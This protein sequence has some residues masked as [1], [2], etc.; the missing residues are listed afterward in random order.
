MNNEA[1]ILQDL[2]SNWI[3][4]VL[5]Y[6]QGAP[7]LR[8]V[9]LYAS[10]EQGTRYVNVCFDQGGTVVRPRSIQGIDTDLSRVSQMMSLF[11]DDLAAAEKSLSNVNSPAPTEYRVYY[12]PS[13]RKLDVQ[14]S[15]ELIYTNHSTKVPSEGIQDWLGDRAPKLL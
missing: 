13:T 1:A 15:R 4:L 2:F 8:A 12:E 7:D 11:F 3:S 5:E 9:Y 10:S 14:L 6:S